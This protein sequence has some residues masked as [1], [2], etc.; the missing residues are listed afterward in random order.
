MKYT[1]YDLKKKKNY[2]PA[3]SI[4]I[5]MVLV[6]AFILG[7]IIYK[8]FVM[9]IGAAKSSTGNVS[10]INKNDGVNKSVKFYGVQGGMYKN[11]G[12]ADIEKNILS[13]YGNPFSIEKNGI[14]R[15]F[16]GIYSS[17]EGEKI[18][19]NL[20][21]KKIDNSKMTFTVVTNDLCDAEITEIINAN[22][23]V[24]EKLGENNVKA[25]QT[26]ELKKWCTS[27][28]SVDEK[29]KNF[30]MLKDL[31]NY[32]NKMPKEISKDKGSGNYIYIYN[33]L[34]KVASK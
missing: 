5:I 30:S 10:T 32:I 29:S 24:L 18:T 16:L 20:T 21:N 12:N 19:K 8:L 25:V 3:F 26:D 11:K 7:T 4:I 27:L 34:Q 15:V 17:D 28:Q 33:I 31:K 13:Q 1:R 2:G 14:T 9:N 6:L 22:L 23:L